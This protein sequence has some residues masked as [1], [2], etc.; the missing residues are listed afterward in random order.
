MDFF[1]IVYADRKLI[2]SARCNC[3][4]AQQC[5]PMFWRSTIF[6]RLP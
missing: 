6:N 2:A 5:F 4:L 3:W 1:S